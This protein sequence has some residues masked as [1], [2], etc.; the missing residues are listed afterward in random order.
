MYMQANS[1]LLAYH[2]LSSLS[3]MSFNLEKTLRDSSTTSWGSSGVALG[4][5]ETAALRVVRF[6]APSV[7]QMR[8]GL[9]RG[10]RWGARFHL[11]RQGQHFRHH[12]WSA[13][14]VWK[15]HS[16]S[17]YFDNDLSYALAYYTYS[18][19]LLFK[20]DNTPSNSCDLTNLSPFH[21]R[22][23]EWRVTALF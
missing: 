22:F 2:S 8:E 23:V 3:M 21:D 18:Y 1:S 14:L 20:L 5:V 16:H 19:W 12:K 15:T 6:V 11:R 10:R 9:E 7:M 17:F 4:T 13:D